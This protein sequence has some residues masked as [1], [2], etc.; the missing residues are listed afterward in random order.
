MRDSSTSNSNRTNRHGGTATT[1]SFF[2]RG[3]RDSFWKKR[4]HN[5]FAMRSRL[6]DERYREAAREVPCGCTQLSSC[7]YIGAGIL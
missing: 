2:L 5:D 3:F 6:Q 7:N 1:F 4:A